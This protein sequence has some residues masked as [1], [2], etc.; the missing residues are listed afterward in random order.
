MFILRK[1]NNQIINIYNYYYLYTIYTLHLKTIF[2]LIMVE[3]VGW[4]PLFVNR[5][6]YK[7]E[8]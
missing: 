8:P 7:T 5:M 4:H 6:V 3:D 1:H 2:N